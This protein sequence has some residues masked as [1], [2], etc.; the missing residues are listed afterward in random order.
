MDDICDS[1]TSLEKT[2]KL[3]NALDTVL[4]KGEFKVKGWV[5]DLT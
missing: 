4:A 2:E 5:S 1:V 3:T